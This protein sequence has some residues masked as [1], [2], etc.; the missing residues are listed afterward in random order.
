MRCDAP[1]LRFICRENLDYGRNH[2]LGG[3]FDEID[4]VVVFDDVH[5]PWERV[6]MLLAL[7]PVLGIWSM[8]RL[9]SLPAA[10]RMASGR[11]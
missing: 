2:P 6:F 10:A 7:G 11:R 5:V 8:W 1:G 3:R 9:R 4:A